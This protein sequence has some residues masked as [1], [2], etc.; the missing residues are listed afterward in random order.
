MT[1]MLPQYVLSEQSAMSRAGGKRRLLPR[2]LTMKVGIG[3]VAM[4]AIV[5]IVS[6]FWTPYP[7]MAPATGPFFAAPSWQHPFGT[8]AVGADIFSRALVATHLDVGITCAVVSIAL[9][10]G[11]IWG[12]LIAFYGGWVE[13]LSLRILQVMQ[14]FPALLLAML[15][16]AAMGRS[17]I[18][19]IL[20]V[21]LL[22]L[23]DYV[24]LARAEVLTKKT[25]QFAEAARMTGRRPLGVLFRHIV[26]N[27]MRPLFAYA[28]IN[29]SWV[30]ATVGALGYVGLGIQPGSAEWGSMIAGGQSAIVTGQWWLSFFPGLGIFL[31][32]AAFHLIGDGLMDAD[33]VRRN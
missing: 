13:Q 2:S 1:A 8:D 6:A 18:D 21:S 27:S 7:P 24:R 4:F 5:A 11:T 19:V 26:P 30:A 17:I 10:V 22:P 32:A 15:V 23:P 25:W 31:L 12:S 20:V 16:I 9:F 28:G 29:A 14:S 33:V 3:V